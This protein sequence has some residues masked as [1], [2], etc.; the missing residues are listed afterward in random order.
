MHSHIEIGS[1]NYIQVY[2]E[3]IKSKK[4]KDRSCGFEGSR[5]NIN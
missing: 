4:V 3:E 1:G 2:I 5:H